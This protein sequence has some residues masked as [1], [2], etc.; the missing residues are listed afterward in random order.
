MSVDFESSD[1]LF[2]ELFVFLGAHVHRESL[3]SFEPGI[4]R[5]HADSPRTSAFVLEQFLTFR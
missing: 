5:S 2:P 4:F 1:E 3:C